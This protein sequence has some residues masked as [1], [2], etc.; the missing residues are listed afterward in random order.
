[1]YQIWKI[2]TMPNIYSNNYD[3]NL[4]HITYLVHEMTVL[5]MRIKYKRGP[6]LTGDSNT[7]GIYSKTT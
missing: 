2:N 1:V 4:P 6:F 5:S 3:F 7:T